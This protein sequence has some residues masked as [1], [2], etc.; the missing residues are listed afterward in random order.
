M[1]STRNRYTG[2]IVAGSLLVAESRE[3][4]RLLLDQCDQGRWRQA[5]VVDNVLQKR[6]PVA[7]KRQ[8]RL[9]KARLSLMSPA[10]WEIIVNGSADVTTQ[11]V[12]AAAIKH[13]RLLADFMDQV[14]RQHWQTFN[15]KLSTRDWRDYLKNCTQVQPSLDQWSESTRKKLK[16]VVF[17]ILAEAGYVDGTK[18]LNLQPVSVIPEIRKY[19]VDHNETD[20]LRCMEVTQ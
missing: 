20:I 7:A 11:A 4:A 10:L 14:I 6:S 12:L 16:Q 1:H 15:T 2:D 19:L 18:T 5:I 8:A 9:I 3:I 17:R 13:S